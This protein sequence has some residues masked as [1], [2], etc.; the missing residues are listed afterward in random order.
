MSDATTN[1]P[2]LFEIIRTTRS[3][4]RLK[5]DPGVDELILICS[6][7]ILHCACHN[8]DFGP[9]ASH[10]RRSPIETD[11]FSIRIGHHTQ[12]E[13]IGKTEGSLYVESIVRF[14]P[15]PDSECCGGEAL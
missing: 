15:D 8:S 12:R 2:D 6:S 1:S 3:M 14:Q 7:P 9:A 4:R 13:Q 5:P 11:R 10:I